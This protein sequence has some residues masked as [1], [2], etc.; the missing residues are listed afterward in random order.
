MLTE[1]EPVPAEA[2][3]MAA[4]RDHLRLGTGFADDALQDGILE[5]ALRAALG[6]VEARIGRALIARAF[7]LRV[8]RWHDATALVLPVGPVV[9]LASF[10]VED[11]GG[12]R[13]DALGR[14]ALEA[15]AGGRPVVVPRGGGLLPAIPE[16]GAA[17]VGFAAGFGPWAGVPADLRQA[18]LMLAASFYED[19]GAAS[20][21]GFPPVVGALLAPWR[22]LRLGARGVR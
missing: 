20:A 17:L 4:L 12:G 6:T 16:G 1:L 7:S 11:A 3:P 14:V 21:T 13:T 22:V 9:A 2:L 18:A 15:P 10:E 8:V 5:A 19:R